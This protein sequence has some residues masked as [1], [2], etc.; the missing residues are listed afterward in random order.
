MFHV[1][2][3]HCRRQRGLALAHEATLAR[4]ARFFAALRMTIGDGFSLAQK[5]M[6]GARGAGMPRHAPTIA[7]VGQ[8]RMQC[9]T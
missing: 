4:V 2:H 1:K 9:F 5:T 6:V 7:F 3:R 8:S